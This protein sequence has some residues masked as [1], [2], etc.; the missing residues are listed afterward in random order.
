[1]GP[2]KDVFSKKLLTGNIKATFK[3]ATLSISMHT[4]DNFNKKLMEIT[5]HLF[6]T[7]VVFSRKGTYIGS[8]LSLGARKQVPGL[9]WFKN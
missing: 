6:P 9:V 4:V 3:Q 5:K 8:K 2:Q 7:Y 1:M